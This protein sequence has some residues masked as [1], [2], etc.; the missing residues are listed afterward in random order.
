L[1]Q[2]IPFGAALA[3]KKYRDA[4]GKRN[5]LPADFLIGAHAEMEAEMLLTRDLG[6]YKKYFRSLKAIDS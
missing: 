4:G 5:F 1:E 3:W 6:F 2:E